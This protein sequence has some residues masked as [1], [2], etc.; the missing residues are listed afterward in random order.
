MFDIFNF[1]IDKLLILVACTL[2][3]WQ[4]DVISLS[5]KCSLVVY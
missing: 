2:Q 1:Q 3:E 4:L 5:K